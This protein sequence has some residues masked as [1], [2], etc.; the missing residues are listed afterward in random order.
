[1]RLP[2]QQDAALLKDIA[3][4]PA[5]V[6]RLDLWWLGQSGFLVKWDGRAFLF[7]PYLSDSL[8]K[9]YAATDKPHVRMIGRCLD[10]ALLTGLTLVTASHLHTDHLD[11]ETLIPIAHANPDLPLFL[12]APIIPEAQA[13]LG[14][15]P[16]TYRAL[17]HGQCYQSQEWSIEAVAAA[18]NDLKTDEY[19]QHYYLGFILRCGPFSL[20]H[21]GDTLWHDGLVDTLRPLQCDLML[22]PINGNKPERRVAGNLNG[23]EA[24][25]LAKTCHARLV[26]PCHYDMFEFNTVTPDEFQQACT[27]LQQP[28]KILQVGER[29]TFAHQGGLQV[30]DL[31]L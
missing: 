7:D 4:A 27:Q 5:Q 11:A 14:A 30:G 28:S 12:P 26:V 10:P 19:G 8:T 9:K 13:R 15:A 24:A 31:H 1:M 22:L 3:N 25:T 2:F 18:H 23:T 6:D 16:L 17:T 21:S 29:L 20:Y